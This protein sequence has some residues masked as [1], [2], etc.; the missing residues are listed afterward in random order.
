[1]ASVPVC[2]ST[3]SHGHLV[4]GCIGTHYPDVRHPLVEIS[5]QVVHRI[6]S[7]AN[8][9]QFSLGEPLQNVLEHFL[10]QCRFALVLLARQMKHR[11]DRQ[12]VDLAGSGNANRQAHHDPVVAAGGRDPFGG[13]CHG[14]AKP[15]QRQKRCQGRK[16][17]RNLL[18]PSGAYHEV[19]W[20][21]PGQVAS[22][23]GPSTA[24]RRRAVPAED[25][26]G[27][28]PTPP[29]SAV[30]S[31]VPSRRAAAAGAKPTRAPSPR[32]CRTSSAKDSTNATAR[33]A[34]PAGHARRSVPRSGKPRRQTVREDSH[35]VPVPRLRQDPLEGG[36]VLIAF[37]NRHPRV[38]AVQHAI[39]DPPVC[40]SSCSPHGSSSLVWKKVPLTQS[41]ADGH[42]FGNNK[43]S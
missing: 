1:L 12:A 22:R 27:W 20:S 18:L 8:E 34:P 19:A 42:G 13:R 17:V 4:N 5:Q 40:C 38:G 11:V 39:H 6:G 35:I 14:V 28:P 29:P 9:D 31:L 37:E 2:S 24:D 33:L 41:G 21:P 26:G 23:S 25:N 7:V 15:T 32:Q 3:A 30:R 10:G 43:G 16:G 36:E